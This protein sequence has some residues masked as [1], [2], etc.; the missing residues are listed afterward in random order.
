MACR[1]RRIPVSFPRWRLQRLIYQYAGIHD[2]GWIEH[3][4]RGPVGLGEELWTLQVV[5]ATMVTAHRVVVRDGPTRSDQR[6][7][8]RGLDFVPLL[9]LGARPALCEH[10]VVR[11]R[12]VWIDVGESA[13]HYAVTTRAFDCRLRGRHDGGVEL[14][15]TVPGDS[16]LEGLHH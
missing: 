11:R 1:R 15:K 16:S 4:T 13:G 6:V 14:R 2:S 12:S 7:R 9:Q 8:C 5:P 10:C 3:A